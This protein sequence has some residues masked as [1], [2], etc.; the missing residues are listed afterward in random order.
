[1]FTVLC[2]TNAIGSSYDYQRQTQAAMSMALTA[3]G[4][5]R[6]KM[7]ASF[8]SSSASVDAVA[9]L[10]GWEHAGWPNSAASA[11]GSAKLLAESLRRR[12]RSPAV[13]L[14]RRAALEAGILGSR[15]G[16]LSRRGM[17][18]GSLLSV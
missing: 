3:T 18:V 17:P 2:F 16:P 10:G 11:A 15:L 13:Q 6:L 1:V 14:N 9:A 8:H 12:P 5:D 4:Y 7:G